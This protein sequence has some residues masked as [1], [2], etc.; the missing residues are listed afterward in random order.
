MTINQIG[1]NHSSYDYSTK[2]IGN[3]SAV[4]SNF[5]LKNNL[6]NDQFQHSSKG[7]IQQSTTDISEI[8]KDLQ[9][10]KSKQGLIGKVWD[11]FKNLTGIGA[12][13]NKAEKAIEDFEKGKISEEEMLKKVNGYKEGQK[14]CVDVFADVVSGIGAVFAFGLAVPTG[15]ASL[16]VGLGVA[17]AVGIGAKVGIKASDAL[18]NDR[19]YSGKDLLYDTATG[20]INGLLAPLTN[21]LGNTVTK[22]IGKKLGLK[23]VQEGAEEVA[24]QAVKQGFKQG[25]KSAVL[26]QSTD[27][28]GGSLAKRAVSLGAGM[29]VDGALGGAG[30]NMVRAAL[31]GEN[32]IKAGIQGAVGGLIMAPIIGGGFRVAGKAGRALNAKITMSKVLPDGISTKFKQGSVGD[33][34]LLSTIDGMMNNPTTAKALKKSITKT[35]GGDY[36]VKIG[37]KIVKVAKSSLTDEMLS[38]TT[39]IKI[40]EQAYKQINGSL[41]GG[42]AEVVAKQ[43]GLNPVHIVN[44]SITDELLD[45][46]AKNQGDTVL[47]FGALVDSNGVMTNVSGQRHYFTIKNIDPDTKMVKLTSP[48][49]TSQ[50]IELSYEQVR[51]MGISIDGGTTKNIDLPNA[52]RNIDDEMF[53]GIDV[54]KEKFFQNIDFTDSEINDILSLFGNGLS[55][56][57]ILAECKLQNISVEELTDFISSKMNGADLSEAG[58]KTFNDLLQAITLKNQFQNSPMFDSFNLGLKDI[59]AIKS[60]IKEGDIDELY[61]LLLEKNPKIADEFINNQFFET[62]YWDLVNLVDIAAYRAV[63]PD[64][65]VDLGVINGRSNCVLYPNPTSIPK[66]SIPRG[67]ETTVIEDLIK[68][69]MVTKDLID[70]ILDSDG[71][72]SLPKEKN[73]RIVN[74]SGDKKIDFNVSVDPNE[75][76]LKLKNNGID[77]LTSHEIHV[78]TDCLSDLYSG[79][80]SNVDFQKLVNNYYKNNQSGINNIY[81]FVQHLK[82]QSSRIT[83][84]YNVQ[85]EDHAFMRMLDRNLLSVTDNKTLKILSFEDLINL[86]SKSAKDGITEIN[87]YNGTAGIKL[88]IKNVNGKIIIDSIM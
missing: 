66:S 29:A 31:N 88:I 84:K 2:A 34:A 51:N 46:L 77:S 42:F 11:K 12:G 69:N 13:S 53:K 72:I 50:I 1:I 74:I 44:E 41:D 14:T 40:F 59:D 82:N 81:S 16:A 67:M 73:M 61:F 24:E 26:N 68:S 47:S 45:T 5:V 10:T 87:G 22:T 76:A 6:E 71:A 30:D 17:T 48:T 80:N 32:I 63:S 60:I 27:V 70:I 21:G 38:D 43:F 33:C 83:A 36:N 7:Q 28:V 19:E 85:I 15:G 4:K 75:I 39:G 49:D 78:L 56:E 86:I 9:E 62:F 8:K 52:I 37:D 25:L 79:K 64:D 23:V 3:T 65:V 57:S 35:I 54:Q 55:I 58:L 20:A 18:L